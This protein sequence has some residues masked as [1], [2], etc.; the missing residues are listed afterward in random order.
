MALEVV[1]EMKEDSCFCGPEHGQFGES[2]VESELLSVCVCARVC[3][4]VCVCMCACVVLSFVY[5]GVYT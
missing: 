2:R 3:V 1:V 4:C 5:F